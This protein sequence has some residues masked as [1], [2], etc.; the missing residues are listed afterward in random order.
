MY[1]IFLAYFGILI[2]YEI[3]KIILNSAPT[4]SIKFCTSEILQL[5]LIVEVRRIIF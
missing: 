3:K 1:I 5:K 2:M 4:D